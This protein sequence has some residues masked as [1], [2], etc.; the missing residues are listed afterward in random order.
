MMKKPINRRDFIKL[1]GATVGSTIL[2]A[3]AP[4]IVTQI[5]KETE[6]VKETQ[7]VK[8]VVK[9]TELVKEV[10]VVTATPLP[11]KVPEP[12]TLEVWFHTDVL[13]LLTAEWKDDPNDPVFKAQWY[14]GGLARAA[15]R[16]WLTK[17]PGVSMKVTSHDWDRNLR[18]NLLL[19]IAAGNQPDTTIGEGYCREFTRLGVFS[20]ISPDVAAKC[21]DGAV[22]NTKYKGKFYGLP[23]MTGTS[24]LMIN[25]D[26][27][28]KAGL[29]PAKLPT[30]WDELLTMCKAIQKKNADPTGK[31]GSNAWFCYGPDPTNEGVP[32]RVLPWFSMNG[33]PLSNDDGYPAANTPK[34]VETWLWWN[35]L[36]WTSTPGLIQ[37]PGG[38]AG[39]GQLFGQGVIGIKTG[40]SNDMTSV[41][42]M[43]TN[44]VATTLPLPVG[45]KNADTTIGNLIHS[46]VKGGKGADLA[47]KL[48]EEV[49]T[50][51]EV[52]AWMPN[53]GGIFIPA[54]KSLLNKWE[55]YDKLNAFKTDKAKAMV[56]LTMKQ[57]LVADVS[58]LPPW[59]K[60]GAQCWVDWNNAFL[61]IWQN[62]Q[63][64]TQIK[65]T[66]DALQKSLLSNTGQ[67]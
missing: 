31:W 63:N 47:I 53:N 20:E 18:E 15:W 24:A 2:S 54:M 19:A 27:L 14:W 57:M 16:P 13:D 29:D 3:C 48:V 1:A 64:A 28:Q 17:H 66:L 25:L 32:M 5:V 26:V 4:Q 30:T 36:M 56:R 50:D 58:P 37:Q 33:A 51:E 44:A 10:K 8:E 9:E 55:T 22:L 23:S 7:V 41:G 65:E 61:K 59:P 40:W 42:Q 35:D 52:S 21:A 39:A 6:V 62:K 49:W 46:P 43:G 12:V 34:A 11:T 60:N 38:E 67:S 45:G